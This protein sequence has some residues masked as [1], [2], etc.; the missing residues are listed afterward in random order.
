[1]LGLEKA[2]RLGRFRLKG[3]IDFTIH[4]KLAV[5]C[6]TIPKGLHPYE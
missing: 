4:G 6:L 3:G 5:G 1:M 2:K